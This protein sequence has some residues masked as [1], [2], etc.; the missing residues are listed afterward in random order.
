MDEAGKFETRNSKFETNS[1]D[2]NTNDQNF[3]KLLF[4]IL[5][6]RILILFRISANFIKSGDIR[7]LYA[8]RSFWVFLYYG[9]VYVFFSSKWELQRMF[10]LCGKLSCFGIEFWWSGRQTHTQPQY[11]QM[12]PM[13]SMLARLPAGGDR[14]SASVS[15]AVGQSDHAWSYS[16]SGMRW[17]AL[18]AGVSSK[19]G[20]YA[21]FNPGSPLFEAS[22]N[23]CRLDVASFGVRQNIFATK[24]LK[25]KDKF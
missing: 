9:D 14:V 19:G 24:T 2:Q 20:K 12:R 21:E 6:F 4:R 8:I 17:T 7:I 23:L 1:N 16:L 15:R 13:R 11:D 25:H 18:F 3:N 5:N 22:A 10:G